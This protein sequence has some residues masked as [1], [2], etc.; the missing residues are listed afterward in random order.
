MFKFHINKQPSSIRTILLIVLSGIL[1]LPFFSAYG[2]Y[3]MYTG[4][5]KE[6]QSQVEYRVKS[7]SSMLD[8]I[9]ENFTDENNHEIYNKVLEITSKLEYP[10][11]GY[12]WLLSLDGKMLSHPYSTEIIDQYVTHLTDDNG[13]LFVQK[14]L[15]QA[16]NGGGFVEYSWSKPDHSGH[17]SKIAYVKYNS[18]WGFIIGSGAYLDD[19][20]NEI[21]KKTINTLILLT[22]L[23][24]INT[25]L[26]FSISRIEFSK[27]HSL[28]IKDQL[29][30]LFNRRYFNEV[31]ERLFYRAKT[32]QLPL[33]LV[34]IDIDHFKIIN[35]RFSHKTGDTILKKVAELIVDNMKITDIAI[36]YGGEEFLLILHCEENEAVCIVQNIKDHIENHIHVI[37]G[38]KLNIT[39]SAGLCS[40][41]FLQAYTIEDLVIHADKAMYRAKELGR[42][43]IE[44]HKD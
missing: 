34:F 24:I 22:I 32:N 37:N 5:T 21:N 39:V 20:K 12:Y 30:N 43:R 14:M 41:T 1:T 19:I 44:V 4:I 38:E 3:Q 29:T 25:I 9:K 2:I 26:I 15:Q 17:Y 16:K 31:G 7:L 36:R 10:K 27:L 18:S 33:T 28:A 35:D 6:R 40:N 23:L 42:N 11:G 8:L 13:N